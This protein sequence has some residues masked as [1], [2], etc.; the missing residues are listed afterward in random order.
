[1]RVYCKL[2]KYRLLH[3]KHKLQSTR[4][5]N[6]VAAMAL[7]HTIIYGTETSTAMLNKIFREK[8]CCFPSLPNCI[9]LAL[10][11]DVRLRIRPSQG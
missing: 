10:L 8:P 11:H 9:D 6:N 3:I 5:C 2:D 4:L 7:M 1:M